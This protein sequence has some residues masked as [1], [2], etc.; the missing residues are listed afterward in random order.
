MRTE[1]FSIAFEARA[2]I[3][4]LDAAVVLVVQPSDEYWRVG[5]ILLLGSGEIIQLD[6]ER[7]GLVAG[8]VAGEESAESRIAIEARE[9]A[10]NY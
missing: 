9:A 2:E 5:E 8:R 4:D 7:P 6:A 3:G 1:H 10:P